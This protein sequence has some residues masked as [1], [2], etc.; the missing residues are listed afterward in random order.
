[1]A[2]VNEGIEVTKS[3]ETK[4]AYLD[5]AKSLLERFHKEV[6]TDSDIDNF[7]DWVIGLK[8]EISPATW[9]QYKASLVWFLEKKNH[10]SLADKLLSESNDGCRE[11]KKDPITERKTSARKKKSVTENEELA[12]SQHLNST[13]DQSFWS[14]PTLAFFKATLLTGLRPEEWQSASLIMEPNKDLDKESLPALKVKN[15]KATNGR[16]HGEYRHLHLN[17]LSKKDLLF[18]RLALQYANPRAPDG[19]QSPEG[20]E[21]SWHNYYKKLRGHLYRTVKKLFPMSTR[22]IALYSCR[23]Q[24]IANLKKAKFKR[25][26]IAAL[27]GHATD[28][29]ASVHYGRAKFGRSRAGLPKPN[30]DEVAKV[31]MIF[32]G[33]PAP[34]STP[35]QGTSQ[36]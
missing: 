8:P 34:T 24:F 11:I 2:L 28:D 3:D 33:R 10:I 30:M 16:A 35:S 4:V 9:R 15:A 1:M 36:N 19:W 20:K 22:K 18:I 12:I 14:R 6:G 27:V 32:Q 5:R 13:V 23:H 29:T 7:V 17:D 25:E 21:K 31:R 26:E